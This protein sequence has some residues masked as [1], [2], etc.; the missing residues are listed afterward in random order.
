MGLTGRYMDRQNE[1]VAITNQMD[2][3]AEATPRAPQRM[4]RRLLELRF[5]PPAQPPGG[6]RF[7][8]PLLRQPY[9]RG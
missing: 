7:F 3:G 6:A 5:F 4:V 9:W 1:A 8:F 2:L